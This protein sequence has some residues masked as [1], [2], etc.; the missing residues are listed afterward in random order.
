MPKLRVDKSRLIEIAEKEHGD[1]LFGALTL[2][3]HSGSL[4]YSEAQGLLKPKISEWEM[5]ECWSELIEGTVR[6]S[7]D[8][9]AISFLEEIV[10]SASTYPK[11]IR[12]AALAK[13][14]KV[15]RSSTIDIL[16]QESRLGLPFQD[17]LRLKPKEPTAKNVTQ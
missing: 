11:A 7:D 8:S 14:E 5:Q 2:L 6:S 15:A 4:T 12:Y 10:S 16:K 9:E 13:Y 17:L 3:A 1:A